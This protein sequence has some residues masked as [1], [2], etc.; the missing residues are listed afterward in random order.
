M[1]MHVPVQNLPSSLVIT[2][3]DLNDPDI[4][5]TKQKE[6]AMWKQNTQLM[7]IQALNTMST[8]AQNFKLL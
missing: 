7:Y 3:K 1:T 2:Q 8:W 4:V 6:Q 5:R